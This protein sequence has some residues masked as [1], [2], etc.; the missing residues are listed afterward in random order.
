MTKLSVLSL[1]LCMSFLPGIFAQGNLTVTASYDTT[2]WYQNNHVFENID[3]MR[4]SSG[5]HLDYGIQFTDISRYDGIHIRDSNVVSFGT[6]EQINSTLYTGT[7][8]PFHAQPMHP[9]SLYANLRR[10]TELNH[11]K[12]SG[13]LYT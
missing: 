13:L 8:R 3:P 2:L 5:I 10:N 7:I 6:L 9:E 11:L 12:L 1:L 4:I